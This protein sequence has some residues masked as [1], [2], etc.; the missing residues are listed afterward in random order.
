[1]SGDFTGKP[2]LD[3]NYDDTRVHVKIFKFELVINKILSNLIA[4]IIYLI[5]SVLYFGLPVLG[6]LTSRYIGGG[7][8][9]ASFMW[10]LYWWPHAIF[11]G[12]NPLI[13][14]A[15]WAPDGFNLAWSTSIPA[16][17]LITAPL[18]F[19]IGPVASYNILML[20]SPALAALTTYV[21]VYH[22]T[23]SF[24][25]SLLGG[26]LFGFST[27]EIGQMLGHLNLTMIFLIPLC[28]YLVLLFFK[29][30]IGSTKFV[31]LMTIIL[32]LQ[33]LISTEVFLTLT[34]FGI[35]ALALATI[36]MPSVRKK[37]L[38]KGKM[39]LGAYALTG[40]LVSPFLY[41]F[42]VAGP[43][44]PVNPPSVFSSDLLNIFL[45]T[46]ITL[47]GHNQFSV[48]AGKFSGNN[49][50]EKG[51]YIGLPLLLI[52][53]IYVLRFW[54]SRA[55]KLLII[56]LGLIILASLGPFLHVGGKEII[57]L[58]WFIFT[59][60]PLT[61]QA[62]PARFMQYAFLIIALIVGIFLSSPRINTMV[63]YGLISLSIVSIVFLI[64]NTYSAT[65]AGWW[66]APV[67][68]PAFFS[69]GIYKNYITKGENVLIIPYG[70]QGQSMLWQA[71]TGMYF[72][73]AGGYTGYVPTSFA[74]WPIMN[75]WSSGTL[76]PDYTEQLKAFLGSK[77][78]HA[79]IVD[80]S[81]LTN[82]SQLFDS[83]NIKSQNIDGITLY[84][85]PQEILS[86]YGNATVITVRRQENLAQFSALYSAAGSF[87]AAGGSVEEVYPLALED[88]GYLLKDLGGY[89]RDD[90]SWNWTRLGGWAGPWGNDIG[91]GI[92]GSYDELLPVID[93]YQSQAIEI[94]FPYPSSLISTTNKN[95]T[96]QLLMVFTK[97]QVAYGNETE[98]TAL[99]RDKL[100]QFSAL[101]SAA[102]S[103]LAAG[104]S[105]EEVYPLALE[106]K[107]YLLKDLG[108]YARDD[109]SW[110]WTRFDGWAGPWGNDIG[111]GIIGS[112]D[113]LLPVINAYQSRAIEIYFPYPSSLIPTTDKNVTGQLLVIFT[114]DQVK[115]DAQK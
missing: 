67:S 14:H 38:T 110:N 71:E 94:Y 52:I 90:P 103:F 27:Y 26:Y 114:K 33:F 6:H 5:I 72:Q 62:L 98:I 53:L 54:R 17:S 42:L 46:P 107:G 68:T 77:D 74:D 13:T 57:K 55:G 102:G 32:L 20:L 111:I 58:P 75:A 64:P 49:F 101:Y 35:L 83:L 41:Y 79:V 56:S 2:G 108:G 23:K 9:P 39:I 73:M 100:A 30:R 45:P 24:W 18:T 44:G 47:I 92:T 96:G 7:T 82:F 28:V 36:I 16:L 34:I 1:M 50:C 81:S 97:N 91:I 21:L 89:A 37:I 3:Q 85:I 112:Y 31:V 22:L 95:V 109:P 86:A 80:N 76:I 11:H 59:K 106:D 25:P 70:Y 105:V 29:D 4:F 115:Q 113:E 66:S 10:Y 99:R 69:Q 93:A 88:K 61:E 40:L 51:A 48:L 84:Q 12:L 87:L 65:Y 63:K 19:T 104:G 78:I 60:I 15:V 43:S 8:D